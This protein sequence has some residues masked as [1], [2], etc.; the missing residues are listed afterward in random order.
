MGSI[1]IPARKRAQVAFT[2]AVFTRRGGSPFATQTSLPLHREITEATTTRHPVRSSAPN[3]SSGHH[4]THHLLF[5]MDRQSV[6]T[7]RLYG[8]PAETEETNTQIRSLLESFILDFRLDNVFVYRFD[9]CA[10][11]SWR[12]VWTDL[13]LKRPTS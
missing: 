4:K 7:S 2:G 6:F 1:K 3:L 13:C 10:P 12:R 9:S 8:T 5:T 11:V